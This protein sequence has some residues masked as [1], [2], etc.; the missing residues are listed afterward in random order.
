[1]IQKIHKDNVNIIKMK[2][3]TKIVA[4]I[5]QGG[6][7]SYTRFTQRMQSLSFYGRLLGPV[8]DHVLINR[9]S[10]G[11]ALHQV[12]KYTPGTI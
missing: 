4:K 8:S 10:K 5:L 1:M 9:V 6:V 12:I 11:Q 7:G 3:K 2:T